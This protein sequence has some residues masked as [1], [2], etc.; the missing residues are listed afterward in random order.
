[1]SKK[2]RVPKGVEMEM[3][4]VDYWRKLS[5]KPSIPM[6]DGS[7]ISE[8]DYMNKFMKEYYGG[9]FTKNNAEIL[10]TED[11]MKEARRNN[12]N[13]ERDAFIAAKKNNFIKPLNGTELFSKEVKEPWERLFVTGTDEQA[14]DALLSQSCFELG[15]EYNEYNVKNIYKTFK[16]I[17]KLIQLIKRDRRK[18][19]VKK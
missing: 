6:P 15:I 1:M 19:Y 8:Y 10:Q 17:K 18:Y 14:K 11:Q 9:G 13:L 4:D 12:H 2:D 7:T 3:K 5:K 16:R